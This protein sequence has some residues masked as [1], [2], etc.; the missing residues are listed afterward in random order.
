M[1]K[2]YLLLVDLLLIFRFVLNEICD[3]IV[4]YYYF[5]FYIVVL[6]RDVF[7]EFVTCHPCVGD[8]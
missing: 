5:V 4:N 6:I 2:K 3:F 8:V 1:R 7:S